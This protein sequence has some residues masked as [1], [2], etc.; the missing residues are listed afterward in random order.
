MHAYLQQC[1]R[2]KVDG[3]PTTDD[4]EFDRLSQT[5]CE[6]MAVKMGLEELKVDKIQIE[7]KTDKPHESKL[8]GACKAGVCRY[9][10]KMY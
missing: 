5:F 6:G 2:C 7:G 9:A 4:Y 10:E 3:L 1:K 8:C